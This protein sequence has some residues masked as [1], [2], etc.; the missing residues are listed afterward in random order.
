MLPIARL[1]KSLLC[2]LLAAVFLLTACARTP[3]EQALRERL[4]VLQRDIDA[5]K[6]DAVASVLAE[7]FVGNDG[8]DRREARRIAA[9]LFLR[10]RDVGVRFGPLQVEMR[11]ERHA[12]VRFSAAASGGRGGLLPQDAQVYAV[13]TGWRLDGDDWWMTSAEWEPRL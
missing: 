12:T 3:P 9:G 7:D 13:T 8:V 4:D 5:R 6:A 10:Y 2:A 11:G 1:S